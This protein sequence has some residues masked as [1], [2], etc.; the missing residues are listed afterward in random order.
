MVPDVTH[1]TPVARKE[2]YELVASRVP[3]IASHN[4]VQSMNPE[5]YNLDETDVRAIAA[6]GGVVGVIF[7]PYWL[8]QSD[9]SNGLSA[10][11]RTMDTVREWS[12]SWEHVAIGT[13]FDGFTDPPNDCDSEGQLPKI[14]KML[15]DKGVSQDDAEAV[16]GG[17]ARRVLRDGWR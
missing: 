3:V 10:I 12:G 16:L 2:L 7:M 14:R 8:D 13:D 15:E 9:P 5:P 6:S 11:W 1:C 4:G 17:N